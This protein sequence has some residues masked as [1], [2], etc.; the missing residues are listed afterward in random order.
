MIDIIVPTYIC[1]EWLYQ[2]TLECFQS[3]IDN[4][5]DFRIIWIDNGSRSKYIDQIIEQVT[6]ID[7]KILVKRFKEQLGFIKATNKGLD[8]FLKGNATH[9]VLLNNDTIVTPGWLKSMTKY[10]CD[11][12][13][14]FPCD[15]MWKRQAFERGKDIKEWRYDTYKR[16]LNQYA[17]VTTTLERLIEVEFITFYCALFK[18]EVI[19]SVGLLDERFGVGNFDDDDYLWRARKNGF[20]V[21]IATDSYVLHFGNETFKSIGDDYYKQLLKKNWKIF[22]KKHP[23]WQ[24]EKRYRQVEEK[25]SSLE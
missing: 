4:T 1:N 9:V 13:G 17:K 2:R 23:K 11:I 3:V 14:P 24:R 20:K 10:D 6:P 21:G 8:I 15:N 25:L 16:S 19:K 22:K 12:T 5:D 18:R 7:N